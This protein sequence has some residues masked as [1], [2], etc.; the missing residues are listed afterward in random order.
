M[1]N[2][3]TKGPKMI[4]RAPRSPASRAGQLASLPK[5][6]EVDEAAL[7]RAEAEIGAGR[8]RGVG[9]PKHAAAATGT[10]V[11]A[12]EPD[13]VTRR[14]RKMERPPMGQMT[15]RAPK[16]IMDAFSQYKEKGNFRSNWAALEELMLRCGVEVEEFDI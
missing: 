9:F 11:V 2:E 13:A 12:T 5:S 15:F 1:S 7:A 10:D 4:A 3:V 6:P 14:N 16:P 8:N